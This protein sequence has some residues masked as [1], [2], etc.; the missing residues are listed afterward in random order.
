MGFRRSILPAIFLLVMSL[1]PSTSPRQTIEA[2]HVTVI[3]KG[4]DL[5][6][7]PGDGSRAFSGTI[8][9]TLFVKHLPDGSAP[10]ESHAGEI[11]CRVST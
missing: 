7:D 10:A 8:T 1:E 4:Q 2:S 6:D 9:G 11:G 5:I 3:W